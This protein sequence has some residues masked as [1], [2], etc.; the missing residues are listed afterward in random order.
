MAM[1]GLQIFKLLPKTNCGE[2]GVP[3]CMAF[4]MKLAAKS[5]DLA[6]CPYASEEA[7]KVIGAAS[8]PPIR[9]VKIGPPEREVLIGNET[10]MFRHD[11][12]F[13]HP[14]GDVRLPLSPDEIARRKESLR[15]LIELFDELNA[16]ARRDFPGG[17]APDHSARRAGE[18][19]GRSRR[20]V[21]HCD[22]SVVVP[23]GTKSLGRAVGRWVGERTNSDKQV[24]PT[25]ARHERVGAV[26]SWPR[27]FVK[28]AFSNAP[29]MTD[30]EEG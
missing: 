23:L 22:Q 9:L 18:G 17:L 25:D 30:F 15:Q 20:G 7:K 11:K 6:S 19:R 29:S 4:A 26:P 21:K 10:V 27:G 12:T 24:G 2:C 14:V 8:K 3:T 13:V 28:G 5:A 16:E 1:T